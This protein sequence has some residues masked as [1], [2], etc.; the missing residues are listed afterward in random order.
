MAPRD[1]FP[2]YDEPVNIDMEPEDAVKLLVDAEA[3]PEHE[4]AE[5]SE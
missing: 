1:A 4:H 2:G 5:E 3:E